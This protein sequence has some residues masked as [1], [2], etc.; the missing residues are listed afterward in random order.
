MSMS[1]KDYVAIA[2]TLRDVRAG[3]IETLP[4]EAVDRVAIALSR[5]FKADNPLFDKDRF[6]HLVHQR[7]GGRGR[8]VTNRG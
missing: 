8:E 7:Q 3:Y 1:K 5:K 4:R 2:E 6:L